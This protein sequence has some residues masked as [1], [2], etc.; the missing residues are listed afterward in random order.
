MTKKITLE[1]FQELEEVRHYDKYEYH[2]LL[3]EYADIAATPYTGF[4]YYDSAGNYLGDSSDCDLVDLL[5]AAY[6]EVETEE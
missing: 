2:R 6:I 4:A 3:A 1:Q 5:D